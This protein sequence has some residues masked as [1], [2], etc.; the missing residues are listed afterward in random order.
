MKKASKILHDSTFKLFLSSIC[1]CTIAFAFFTPFL[2]KFIYIQSTP[3]IQNRFDINLTIYETKSGR[4]VENVQNPNALLY[5]FSRTIAILLTTMFVSLSEYLIVRHNVKLGT[6]YKHIERP[7]TIIKII[8]IF[9]GLS[10]TIYSLYGFE[11]S[12]HF[13]QQ[14]DEPLIK[15]MIYSI[16][17]NSRNLSEIL[18]IISASAGALLL[19]F[20]YCSRIETQKVLE[21]RISLFFLSKMAD[22]QM[23]A[24]Q[25]YKKGKYEITNIARQEAKKVATQEAEKAANIALNSYMKKIEKRK[26]Y[27]KPSSKS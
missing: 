16:V 1:I 27:K 12:V 8:L 24:E 6:R 19:P 3:P 18:T 2:E 15:E 26:E 17:K 11:S 5:P 14:P 13:F 25:T 4:F 9:C 21:E 22:I 23:K 10:S 20:D 7:L